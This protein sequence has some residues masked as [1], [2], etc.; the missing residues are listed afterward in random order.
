MKTQMTLGLLTAL[1]ASLCCI[2]PVLAIAAGTS[3]L[4]TSFLWI[5]PLRP[6][7][8]GATF[9]TLGFAWFH[10]FKTTTDDCDCEQPTKKSFLQSRTFLGIITAISVLLIAFP[11]YS[12]Y[13][14]QSASTQ[15]AQDQDKTKR[16]ELVVK[17]MTCTSCEIH[18]EG[19]VKKLP[20]VTFAR[21]SYEKGSA[22]VDYDEQKIDKEKIIA[23]INNTGYT[24]E[25]YPFSALLQGKETCT[26]SSCQ[27]PTG[28]LPNQVNKDVIILRDVS[29]IQKVFNDNSKKTKFIAILSSTCKWCLEGA[30]AIQASVVKNMKTKDV[31]VIIVWTNM[32]QSDQENTALRAASMFKDKGIVQFF[33]AENKFGNHAAKAINPSG[34]SAWDIYMF[35]DKEVTWSKDLPQPFD[36]AHQLG[37]TRTWVDQ[38]KYYCGPKLTERLNYIVN[39]L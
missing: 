4:A 5:D 25:G 16:I 14:H 27:I 22:I 35:F 9:L 26:A 12:K 38:S 28:K 30:D 19:E 20:G 39:S 6:Y 36:Y 37:S 8:V 29:Q 2:T 34:E 17:G 1:S 21:A 23:A 31:S 13:F 18:I 10:S 32:L 33:D 7:F 15:V 24:V 11:S 3:S